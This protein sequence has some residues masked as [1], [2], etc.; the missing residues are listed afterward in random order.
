MP[1][2]Q[3]FTQWMGGTDNGAGADRPVGNDMSPVWRSAKDR[4]MAAYRVTPEAQY[5]DGYL[6]TQGASTRRQDKLVD[7][8]FRTNTRSYSRGVH[9]G[10]RINPGDYLW[11]KEFN[12][13]SGIENEL[14]G[15]RY[16]TG[17]IGQ[18]PVTLVN[19]GKAGPRGVLSAIARPDQEVIDMQRQSMLRTLLPSWR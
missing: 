10:E 9:K 11:P 3:S 6:G 18:E 4:I 17:T 1:A 2:N 16:P 13:M 8:V 7:A 15:M 19:D 14:T 12:L 5:P